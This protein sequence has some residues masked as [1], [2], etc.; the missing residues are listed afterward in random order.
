VCS[1]DL[2]EVVGQGPVVTNSA[3][4]GVNGARTNCAGLTLA[5]IDLGF[6]N[7]TQART[8][9]DAPAAN[10]TFVHNLTTD[11][12]FEGGIKR[13][14]TGVLEAFFDH[15][16]G[17]AAW[18]L[19][20]IDV[21]ADLETAIIDARDNNV[22]VIAHSLAYFNTGWADN[23][24]DACAAI[25]QLSSPNRTLIFTSAGNHAQEHWQGNFSSPDSDAWHDWST[26]DESIDISVPNN[27]SI[28]A[29][30]SWNTAAGAADYDLYLYNAT[31]TTEL[32]RSVEAG[33]RFEGLE[34]PNNTG[35]TQIVRLKVFHRSGGTPEFELFTPTNG[36][37][38]WLELE[39]QVTQSSTPS[40]SNC[41]TFRVVS[42]GAVAHGDF[43]N[44]TGANNIQPY[45]SRGPTNGGFAMP[46]LVGPTNTIG[47][48]YPGGFGGTS[49]AAPNAAGAAAAFWASAPGLNGFGL[50]ELL[51]SKAGRLHDWG[52]TGVD[53]TYGA[54]GIALFAF[55]PNTSWVD[56][57][58]PN[59]DGY[60]VLPYF[61]VHHAQ[62]NTPANGR[63][64]ILSG[65]YPEPITLA[66]PMT[67]HSI[68]TAVLGQ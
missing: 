15:C 49:S 13:H 61:Y 39:H 34:W 56:R 45:S 59:F 9:G 62:T 64:V 60:P 55:A 50:T 37:V 26:G 20:R 10:I 67:Y 68:G 46:D 17:A 63:V 38:T 19:Y 57:H 25:N 1:S 51:R 30:L 31:E 6:N 65:S 16:P 53:N 5:V 40:P 54:G 29:R 35:A 24:G 58:L 18:H 42:V 11:P 43:G 27:Q 22:S 4:Y 21:L 7:L 66:K 33:A 32:D 2:A 23:S 8:N 36:A 14:G 3:S 28:D 47:F 52:T 44:V 48:T 41:I 12:T